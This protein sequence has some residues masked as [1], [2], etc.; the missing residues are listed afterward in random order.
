M[1]EPPVH[2][3]VVEL[4]QCPAVRVRQN[5]LTAEVSRDA[6]QSPYD[7]V[8]RVIPGDALEDLFSLCGAGAVARVSLRGNS[9]HRIQHTIWRVNP[10]QIFRH[11]RTKKPA[12][13]WMR[14]IALDLHR[15]AIVHRNQDSASI[16][17]I[18]RTRGMNYFFHDALIIRWDYTVGV[19]TYVIPT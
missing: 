5:S 17:A 13:D 1:E 14:R 7:F 12:R 16:R 2:G 6:P 4:A 9:P 11:L 10:I 15:L 18:M 8:E 19:R 3:T